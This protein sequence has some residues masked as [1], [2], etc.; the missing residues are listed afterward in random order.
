M[1]YHITTFV[2]I[3]LPLFQKSIRFVTERGSP[4]P[5]LSDLVVRMRAHL[6]VTGTRGLGT[7]RKTLL[8][9][10]SDYLLHHVKVPVCVCRDPDL[11]DT[12]SAE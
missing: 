4:G 8:G 10:V 7:I 12:Q 9:S 5:A 11:M 2:S 3:G 1:F 6:V